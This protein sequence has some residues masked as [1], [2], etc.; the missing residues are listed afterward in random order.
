MKN[1]FIFPGQGSQRVGMGKDLVENFKIAAHT[2]EEASDVLDLDMKKMCF[3]GPE[4]EL[5]KTFNAQPALLTVSIAV[6]R[7]L[8]KESSLRPD[9]VA[10]HSL[11]EYSALVAAAAFSFSEALRLVRARGE[12]MQEA[13]PLG[14]GAMAAILGLDAKKVED[15]C[16]KISRKKHIVAC[17]NFNAPTQIVISGHKD[18]VEEAS[19][20]CKKDNARV[21]PLP[22][23]APFHCD[24]MKSAEEKMARVLELVR[25]QK[26]KTPYIA[27]YDAKLRNDSHE[28]KDLLISQ[29]CHS[30]RWVDCMNTAL[31]CGVEQGFEVG[32]GSVLKGLMKKIDE[33]FPMKT[34][35][36][37]EDLKEV[38]S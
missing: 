36:S 4:V 7:V 28:V 1:L 18:A 15:Y 3:E 5:Q 13:T 31:Q 20:L 34:L 22:V 30:V 11:G 32:Y 29:M 16:S 21:I 8:E 23:S 6:L 10:G 37:V 38:I 2:F 19:Q 26:L 33:Q 25:V 24:L 12:Y 27:N 35:S 14:V 9:I 17:A